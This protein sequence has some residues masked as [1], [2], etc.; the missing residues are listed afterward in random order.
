MSPGPDTNI[1]SAVDRR[2]LP[3]L[4]A[5]LPLMREVDPAA[6]NELA[7]EIEWFSVPG[8]A[9]LFTSGETADCLY[10]IVNGAFGVYVAQP[11]GGS[12]YVSK[13]SGGQTAGDMELICGGV[14]STTLVALRDS[15]VARI[16]RTTFE[17]LIGRH[18]Q[19]LRHL[20]R[21][22]AEQ[23]E[24]LQQTQRRTPSV[25]KTFAIVPDDASVDPLKL[26]A[27]LTASLRHFGRAELVLSTQAAEQTSHWFHRLERANDFI[28][29]LADPYPT[30][31]SRLCLRRS[32]MLLL[33]ANAGGEPRPWRAL[34]CLEETSGALRSAQIVL[35]QRPGRAPGAARWLQAQPQR[36]VHHVRDVQDVARMARLLTGRGVG[37][38]LSGGGARGF[39]HIGVLRALQEARIAV[40]SIGATSI[41]AVIG[42]GWAAGWDYPEMLERIRR[43]FVTS[44]P[45]SDYTLPI[46]SLVAGRKVSR[47]MRQEFGDTD[48]EDLRLPYYCVSAN[49][50]SGQL[51]IHRT[52]KLWLWLRAS[53]AIPGVLP[54]V[55]T[56]KQAYVDG[57]TLNNLPVD[58]MREELSGRI[59]A[60]DTSADRAFVSDLEMTELPP[61][62]SLRRL[63]ARGAPHLNIMQI[64]LRAGMLNSAATSIG[65]RELADMLLK[66][67]LDGV[68]LLD[69]RAFDRAIDLGYRC[70]M[71]ALESYDARGDR[72][73]SLPHSS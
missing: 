6:I 22:L 59:I 55:F 24:S 33:A 39:A 18:P 13:L 70:A 45:L 30:N 53:I 40:D 17:K 34:E 42:A 16:G 57:A 20:A 60:V 46:I 50:T 58:I 64:L 43:S 12:R 3:A 4:F 72:G 35:V 48:I 5:A 15:E 26:G 69:W 41:G 36:R 10:L 19:T 66:P 9:P 54:P 1:Q 11:G 68:D 29:Y 21:G 14:R 63:I 56:Q 73:G 7:D 49:L 47:L 27:N 51:A 28:V 32:E 37:L 8:G 67:Q 44:N 25:P 65:Q 71:R 52:G 62:W 61:L 2:S 31:W 23:L 38:V